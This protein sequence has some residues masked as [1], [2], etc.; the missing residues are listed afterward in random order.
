[1]AQTPI[2]D[3]LRDLR[4]AIR[5][6][7]RAPGFTAAAALTLALGIGAN[8]AVFSAVD[9]A[10]FKPLPFTN[11]DRIVSLFQNDLRKHEPRGDVAPGNFAEW[12]L[13]STTF[14]SMAVAEPYSLVVKTSD[15]NERI[16]NWNVTQDFFSILDVRPAR[17]RLF[18]SSEF[19]PGP[20]RAVILTYASWQRRYGGDERIV[21]R[22]ITVAGAPVTI[23]GVLPRNFSYLTN[24]PRYEMFAPKVLDSLERTL[25]TSGW[26]HA[27]ARLKPG[28][29]IAQSSADINRVAAS[30]A[31][32]YPRTNTD[33]AVTVVSLHEGLVGAASRTLALL[34]GAVV[35]VL[36]IACVNVATLLLART[37]RRRR[38]LDTRAALGASRPRLIQ[39]MLTETFV[40]CALGGVAGVALAYW[41]V[42]VIRGL[43]PASTP[44]LDEIRVDGR[45]LVFTMVA[46]ALTTIVCGVFPALKSPGGN[47]ERISGARVT[48]TRRDR[49]LRNAFVGAEVALAVVLLVGAGL[50]VRSFVSVLGVERGY[51]T[52]RVLSASVFVWQYRPAERQQF[53]SQAIERASA[54]PGVTVAGAATSL[55]LAGAIGADRGPFDIEGHATS[56]GEVKSAHITALT[57]SAFDA[58]EIR[59]HRGRL[60]TPGDD[61][62]AAP[63]A[64]VSET[65][66]RTYWPNEDPVGRRINIG[67]YGAPVLR[68]VVGVVGD[69]RQSSLEAP[70]EAMVFLPHAQTQAGGVAILLRTKGS[71]RA[72][73]PAL[74]RAIASIDATL[75]LTY[76]TTLDE[77]VSDSLK[78]RTFAL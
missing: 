23:V 22:T 10:I 30:L 7:G 70:P 31:K 36:L 48:G 6:L 47:S 43:S 54:I 74:R 53:V 2:E 59:L 56:P 21:G 64:I 77:L 8:T 5:S 67:F 55:P 28:V 66:A 9:A 37:A 26:F 38:E 13:A 69:V 52:D 25:R 51:S 41:G 63:V 16:G 3:V 1:M 14:S 68:T 60:F 18:D 78:P 57:P 62:S 32:E 50:L 24:E 11:P 49:S 72:L 4:Y 35:V 12:Q 73:L 45:A 20:A 39:Q 29:T 58:L 33:Q 65:M 34:L 46:V 61:P 40:L 75:P 42:G 19:T 71:P 44:R 17:G 15:G 27:I 76:I